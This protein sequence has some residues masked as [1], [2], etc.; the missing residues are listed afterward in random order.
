MSVIAAVI[1]L[2]LAA[3]TWITPA[4]ANENTKSRL[5]FLPLEIPYVGPSGEQGRLDHF[6]GCLPMDDGTEVFWTMNQHV[7]AL[8]SRGAARRIWMPP[9]RFAQIASL[10]SD[11]RYLWATV[12]EGGKIPQLWILDPAREKTWQITAEHGLPL[13][14]TEQQEYAYL[15]SIA[16]EGVAPGRAIVVGWF[17]RLWLASIEFDARGDRRVHVFHEANEAPRDPHA[18]DVW[19]DTAAALPPTWLLTLSKVDAG[20]PEQRVLVGRDHGGMGHPLIV[21]PADLSVRAMEDY[22]HI[23]DVANSTLATGELHQGNYYHA[24]IY[25]SQGKAGAIVRIGLPDLKPTPIREKI[26]EALVRFDGKTFDIVGDQ[27]WR[28]AIEG[29]LESMGAVP[30][31]HRNAWGIS[32]ENHTTVQTGGI[33]LRT[34]ARS[35]RYGLIVS[36]YEEGGDSLMAR[37]VFDG[38]G[39]PLREV[40]S[41]SGAIAD[42][43]EGPESMRQWSVAGGAVEMEAILVALENNLVHLRNAG[44][45]AIVLPLNLFSDADQE[46]IR[47]RANSLRQAAARAGKPVTVEELALPI[48]VTPDRREWAESLAEFHGGPREETFK[49]L[50]KWLARFRSN[51]GLTREGV[52]PL[53]VTY[54]VLSTPIPTTENGWKAHFARIARWEELHPASV[55]PLVVKGQAYLVRA[56]QARGPFDA[57]TVSEEGWQKFV[58]EVAKA[59]EAL[60]AAAR[61]GGGDPHIYSDLVQ[62]AKAQGSARSEVDSYVRRAAEID[63]GYLPVYQEMCDYLLPRWHGQPGDVEAFALESAKR[64]GGEKGLEVFGAILLRLGYYEQDFAERFPL[65]MVHDAARVMHRRYPESNRHLNFACRGACMA[66]DRSEAAA[67]FEQIGDEVDELAWGGRDLFDSYRR[68][69]DPDWPR[70]QEKRVLWHSRSGYARGVAWS[71]D[72]KTLVTTGNAGQNAVQIW[73]AANGKSLRSLSLPF[74][75]TTAEFSKDGKMLALGTRE[76]VVL[77]L[78][79]AD[80]NPVR[81]IR[82]HTRQVGGVDFSPDGKWLATASIDRTG[83]V[84]NVE[85]GEEKFVHQ[86]DRALG[87]TGFSRDGRQVFFSGKGFS[88]YD[89]ARGV[90]TKTP[91][92]LVMASAFLSDGSVI[93]FGTDITRIVTWNPRSDELRTLASEPNSGRELFVSR[94]GHY[95]AI[96]QPVIGV[97]GEPVH[98]FRLWLYDTRNRE[99]VG[100][101]EGHTG[102]IA[103]AAFS[104]DGTTLASASADGTVRLWDVAKRR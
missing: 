15:Q 27:W 99:F 14:P 80:W 85:T 68:W 11:G 30:W 103:A 83:R 71:P 57:S 82:G 56:W 17:N 59:R 51:R 20:K 12:R 81:V 24:A 89:V 45:P 6:S 63:P 77:L 66:E 72:G 29:R 91:H 44:A 1:A 5:S 2:L 94:D 104:P 47:R 64:V 41:S 96:D 10:K 65:E 84:W 36:C 70:G 78:A 48:E 35:H 49:T 33:T 39:V 74:A 97:G 69:C 46:Y 100:T 58:E 54:R 60:E 19:R 22:F 13:V 75:V 26:P 38:S 8:K 86:D 62:V 37:V 3:A 32:P 18:K 87:G 61:L 93:G 102:K 73:S 52:S 101:L 50:E 31:L 98:V 23:D 16:V 4:S 90:R 9:S 95:F 25:W 28:T 55:S 43:S 42:G 67:L 88:L 53:D 76:G 34:L 79:V 7:I 92:R 40:R 21:D